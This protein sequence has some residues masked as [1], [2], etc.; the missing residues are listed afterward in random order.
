MIK[1]VFAEVGDVDVGPAVAIVVADDSTEA[2]A[3]VG[4]AGLCCDVCKG[5]V[6]IVV[7]QGGVRRSSL[8]QVS[9]VGRSV[10]KIDI[11]PAIVV[12][13][14]QPHTRAYRLDDEVLLGCT[15]LVLKAC[16]PTLFRNVLK[17]DRSPLDGTARSDW[18]VFRVQHRSVW[19][20]RVHPRGGRR[21]RP[22]LRVLTLLIIRGLGMRRNAKRGEERQQEQWR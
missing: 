1:P 21:L 14:E 11:E 9:I 4:H 20:A 17:H 5:P 18:P 8:P 7:E 22:F 10:H 3:I 16:N 12:V 15:H 13:V 19:T 2:P 6:M